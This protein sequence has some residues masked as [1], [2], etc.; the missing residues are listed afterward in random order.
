MGCRE[1]VRVLLRRRKGLALVK[2]QEVW[3]RANIDFF[4]HIPNLISM[5]S[6]RVGANSSIRQANIVFTINAFFYF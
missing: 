2:G 6:R 4:L 3:A 1:G 5:E